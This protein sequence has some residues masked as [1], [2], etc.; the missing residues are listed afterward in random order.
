MHATQGTMVRLENELIL[1]GLQQAENSLHPKD[2]QKKHNQVLVVFG[3][4][5]LNPLVSRPFFW[6]LLLIYILT[7]LIVMT[8][9]IFFITKAKDACAITFFKK[10]LKKN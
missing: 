10:Y 1:V 3:L 7:E 4:S 5:V 2:R 9:L 6:P 8:G